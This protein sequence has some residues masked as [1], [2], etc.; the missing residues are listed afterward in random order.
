MTIEGYVICPMVLMGSTPTV[1]SD[2]SEYNACK[3]AVDGLQHICDVEEKYE[4]LIENYIEWENAIS[5][6]TL[7]QMVSFRIAYN[8]VQDLRKLAA[9]KL[10]NLLASARLYLDSLPKHTKQILPGNAGALVQI[11]E[12][13]RIQYDSR[14][15]YRLMEALRNYSQ[16]SALPVHGITTSAMRQSKAETATLDYALLPII[17]R[18]QLAQDD[19]FKKAVLQEISK[20]EQI[21]FKPMVR[22]YIESLSIVHRAFRSIINPKRKSWTERLESAVYRFKKQFPGESTPGLAVS[23]VDAN[24]LKANEEVYVADPIVAY[25]EHLQLKYSTMMH[26]AKSRAVF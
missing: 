13:T 25:L 3:S 1:A 15:S 21:E 12:A 22:E 17:D 4:N 26:F 19:H 24:G 9:R 14:L 2:E 7:R 23:P 10:A 5:Q 11:K 20:L 18:E 8:D 16:H 6:H